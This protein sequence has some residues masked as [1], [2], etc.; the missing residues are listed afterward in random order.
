VPLVVARGQRIDGIDAVTFSDATVQP[1]AKPWGNVLPTPSGVCA[2]AA[3][4]K[5]DPLALAS[6]W[7]QGGE[8]ITAAVAVRDLLACPHVSVAISWHQRFNGTEAIKI[9]WPRPAQQS[10]DTLWLNESTYALIGVTFASDP[11]PP[12]HQ[13]NAVFTSSSIQLT[14]LPPTK[15][16]LALFTISI[17]RGFAGASG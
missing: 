6:G 1:A 13:G 11:G 3:V 2:M 7:G 8:G 5:D 9:V 12:Q 4:P 14:W 15:A 16:N 10:T 17:P